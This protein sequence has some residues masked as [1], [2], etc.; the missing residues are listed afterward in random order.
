MKGEGAERDREPSQT[1][2]IPAG[3]SASS[4]TA[5]LWSISPKCSSQVRVQVQDEQA[6]Q[7]VRWA[8]IA[9][10][11]SPASSR[12]PAGSQR[13]RTPVSDVVVGDTGV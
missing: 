7:S 1:S 2:A 9:S 12:A 4:P 3:P 11:T 10:Q 8:S 6:R 13:T 5:K